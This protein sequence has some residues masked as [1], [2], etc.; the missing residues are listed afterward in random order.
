MGWPTW[1]CSDKAIVERVE[2]NYPNIAAECRRIAHAVCSGEMSANEIGWLDNINAVCH[3]RIDDWKEH[4]WKSEEDLYIQLCNDRYRESK[5]R[6]RAGPSRE[7][8]LKSMDERF[9]ENKIRREQNAIIA[10]STAPADES[11][12]VPAEAASLAPSVAQAAQVY[13][14]SSYTSRAKA[15]V[16]EEAG[17]NN[18]VRTQLES[19]RQ[20][21]SAEA[22]DYAT[23]LNAEYVQNTAA[24][25][26]DNVTLNSTVPVAIEQSPNTVINDDAID[27]TSPLSV[28]DAYIA[29]KS[30]TDLKAGEAEAAYA[31]LMQGDPSV[32][33]DIIKRQD[34]EAQY[35]AELD[36]TKHISKE[37]AKLYGENLANG[38][39]NDV[40]NGKLSANRLVGHFDSFMTNL[41]DAIG[42][43][44][45]AALSGI[46]G[47]NNCSSQTLTNFGL[48][49]SSALNMI[50]GAANTINGL[51]TFGVNLADSIADIYQHGPELLISMAE[52]TAQTAAQTALMALRNA[53]KTNCTIA[54]AMGA[55]KGAVAVGET[56]IKA[57]ISLATKAKEL[58]GAAEKLI[59]VV[60]KKDF[61]GDLKNRVQMHPAVREMNRFINADKL[62]L[63]TYS[64]LTRNGD[65]FARAMLG[66]DAQN[67]YSSI[68][69]HSSSI[70]SSL[71]SW[72]RN[73]YTT[74]AECNKWNMYM[75][76]NF[77]LA[78]LF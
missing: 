30:M 15:L 5:D 4:K 11:G 52:T 58:Q 27:S 75:K 6:G 18:T 16:E 26:G 63:A 53:S 70:P 7:E 25:L 2:K 77:S 32:V 24:A 51:A 64:R 60:E 23:D 14:V 78:D 12:S 3:D 40:M 20:D 41:G 76:Q 36:A 68:K 29:L 71:G 61:V 47:A 33:A 44:V 10:S 39:V 48:G 65:K 74:S 37:L 31:A 45:G 67:R 43:Y 46:P 72:K 54:F 28:E 22:Q 13:D 49:V 34:E 19:I 57:G 8:Q 38:I 50:N 17:A 73:N 9:A 62:D 55:V 35:L 66:V 56:T 59:N 42:M 21:V 69:K 1:M